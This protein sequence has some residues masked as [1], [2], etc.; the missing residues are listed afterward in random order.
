MHLGH[1]IFSIHQD[2]GVFGSTQCDV[3]HCAFL[4]D[5]D[6]LAAEHGIDPL[7]QA[8]LF[9]Q[10]QQQA[11][12]FI[13]DP[14]LGV[15]EIKADCFDSHALAALRITGKELAQVLLGECFVMCR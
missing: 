7:A 3:Q 11:H 5:I 8:R 13:G 6:L 4:R 14:I 9:R 15:I 2:G 1:N 12:G 10:F